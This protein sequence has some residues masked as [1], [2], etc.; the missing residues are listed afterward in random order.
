MR[1]I[2][3]DSTDARE[4]REAEAEQN[5]AEIQER[6]RHAAEC[7]SGWLG[8]DDA[9]RPVACP[10]CRPHLLHTPCHTCS[11]P[12]AACTTQQAARRGPCCDTCDH[13]RRRHTRAAA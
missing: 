13:S 4:Q 3:T 10:R 11:T 6:R 5:Q 9:G 1:S 7:R 2:P 8:E 12:Y